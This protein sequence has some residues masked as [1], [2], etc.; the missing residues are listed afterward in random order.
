MPGIKFPSFKD[1]VN[2]QKPEMAFVYVCL[3]AISVMFTIIIR[4]NAKQDKKQEKSIKACSDKT[5]R[6]RTEVAFLTEQIRR[7]DSAWAALNSRVA[8]LTELKII[9]PQ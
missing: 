2:A 1:F 6:L 7:K 8:V 3:I 5:D 4:A 9:P